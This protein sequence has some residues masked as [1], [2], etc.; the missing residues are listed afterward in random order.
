MTDPIDSDRPSEPHHD[1]DASSANAPLQNGDRLI[2]IQLTVPVDQT[3]LL[4]GLEIWQRLGLISDMQLRRLGQLHLTCAVPEAVP[5][6]VAIADPPILIDAE[7]SGQ[8][9]AIVPAPTSA[10]IAAVPILTRRI[11][12]LMAEISVI[13]LLFLGVFMVVVSSGALAASQWRNFPPVGQY[14]I[15]ATYTLAFWAASLWS[16]RQTNLRLT[17]QMLQITTL[18]IIP[19]NF[20]VM[21]QLQVWGQFVG[22]VVALGIAAI[23]TAIM[24]QLLQPLPPVH[25]RLLLLT[26]MG[27]SWL[28]WGWGWSGFPLIATYAGTIA[29]AISLFIHDRDQPRQEQEEEI[30]L[31]ED[32]GAFLSP[33]RRLAPSVMTVMVATLLLIARAGWVAQVPIAQLG[34]A[35]GICGWLLCWRSRQMVDHTLW[36]G[37]G[38]GFLLVGW[39]VSVTTEVP[40][41]AIAVSGLVIWLYCTQLVRRWQAQDVTLLFLVGLQAYWLLWRVI[42][43]DI[44]QGILNVCAQI[45]GSTFTSPN[46]AGVGFF[47]YVGLTLWLAIWLRRRQQVRLANYTEWLALGLGVTLTLL[48]LTNPL[49]RSLNLILSTLALA[50]LVRQ[51][52]QPVLVG[53]T[54]TVGL[55]AIA[56]AIDWWF[57]Y[58]NVEQWAV[59]LLIGMVGEWALSASRHGDRW[60]QSAWYLGWVLAGISYLLLAEKGLFTSNEWGVV[61]LVTPISLTLLAWRSQTIA[62][63]TDFPRPRLTAELSIL[64]LLLVQPLTLIWAMPRLLSLGVATGLMVLNTRKLQ[65][66]LPAVLTIGFALSFAAALIWQGCS[67]RL[68][69]DGTASLWSIAILVLWL[70]RASLGRW[71]TVLS[72]HYVKASDRWASF[73]SSVHLLGL[74]VYTLT[75]YLDLQQLG[76]QHPV[77]GW[78]TATLLLTGAIAYRLWQQSS[79]FGFCGLAWG[80]ELLIAEGLAQGLNS[81]ITASEGL[82]WKLAIANLALGLASQA[83]GDFWVR[84]S[85]HAYRWSWH[86]IPIADAILGVIFSLGHFTATSGLY[87]FAAALVGI[88]V[89]RRHPALKPLTYLSL[90]GVSVAAYELLIYQLLQAQGGSVG[91]G[92]VLLAGLAIALAVIY[93]GLSRWLVP[94]LRLSTTTLTAIAQIHW[95]ISSGL[96]LLALVSPLS[97]TGSWL[98]VS[99]T[100]LLAIDALIQGRSQPRWI[101]AG[102]VAAVSAVS[103]ALYLIVPEPESLLTWAGAIASGFA[104]GMYCLPWVRWGWQIK[105]WQRSAIGLPGAIVLLTV[106]EIGIPGLLVT[107]AFYAWVARIQ[108]RIRLSYISLL[109]TDWGMLR[110]LNAAQVQ[111]PLWYASVLGGS[112]LYVA[113]IDP[114]L[115]SPTEREKRHLLRCLAVGLICLTGFYQSE[116][117]RWLALLTLGFSIALILAGLMLQIRAFLYV[118][119]ATFMLQILRQLWLLIGD[120]SLALWA[121][122][123]LVG[124]AFIWIA[125]TFES[126]R[127]Q[128]TALIRYWTVQLEEWE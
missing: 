81:T 74:T 92:I 15:L 75:L 47:P 37:S 128:M 127:S 49:I 122:G 41:Q 91:D 29:A 14:G 125:A 69:L 96:L 93:R 79:N 58:L 110:W 32:R 63:S 120:Y 64:A 42:P 80:V 39:L 89:G 95:V 10:D 26:S 66:F 108:T 45:A 11:Q 106:Q 73:L 12:S 3:A 65:Q 121:I 27:L 97:Q 59:L 40:W 6:V 76:S 4:E 57:P 16:S 25:P 20:W 36:Y 116:T 88:G 112:L 87:L 104:Y 119:T 83:A 118:G 34:L 123:I 30:S 7:Q 9:A 111:E 28:H 56:S 103:Q 38:M 67:D 1:A 107:A 2:H 101:Y 43:A 48:S 46:L 90:L 33:N 13:W 113:Q 24:H 8:L 60:R 102:I 53:L 84:R 85:N 22:W 50:A 54:H 99:V 100:T 23:L 21:D 109:L 18:L 35:L 86:F 70:L 98:W 55:G 117:D 77:T 5:E 52:Q 114:G 44:R 68:T 71:D 126:R 78:L 82:G 72:R 17:S 115:R 124:L 51:R 62:W 94:Y 61:W 105:P 31:Q 19:I